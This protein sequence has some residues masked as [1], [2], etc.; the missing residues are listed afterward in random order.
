VCVCRVSYVP[1]V[2]CVCAVW[3]CALC[4]V[5][6][7][8]WGEEGQTNHPTHEKTQQH[9]THTQHTHSAQRTP[10]TAQ[11]TTVPQHSIPQHSTIQHS[12]SVKKQAQKQFQDSIFT[13]TDRSG[14]W[15]Y[16]LSALLQ[17]TSYQELKQKTQFQHSNMPSF[18]MLTANH[19][20][21][22]SHNKDQRNIASRSKIINSVPS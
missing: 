19:Q 2:L 21:A 4:T 1:C 10:R 7:R 8:C 22:D 20:R 15:C 18:M 17:V 9:N 13:V 14:R 12:T 5:S 3:L 16:P 11:Y 6:V